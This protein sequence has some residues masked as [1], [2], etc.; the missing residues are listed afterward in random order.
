MAEKVKVSC[1]HCGV[2]NYYPTESSGKKVVCGRCKGV[3]PLPGTVVEPAPEQAYNLFQNSSL[4]ILID[5][6][7]PTCAPCQMMHPIVENLA[8]RRA[9]ELMVV[10]LN[11][12]LNPEPGA[13][14]GVQGVPTFIVI[15]K[16]NEIGRTSGVMS[17]ADFA[18]WVANKV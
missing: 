10:R 12:N 18:L 2:T 13:A 5:F 4:P 7:S 9:G 14:F 3:L 8:R 1:S 6:Y 11:V 17:E 16:G 15:R